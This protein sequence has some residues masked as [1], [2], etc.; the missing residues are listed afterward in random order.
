M[1][2]WRVGMGTLEYERS[3]VHLVAVSHPLRLRAGLAGLTVS[4]RSVYTLLALRS[5]PTM[6]APIFSYLALH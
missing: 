1:E 6:L 3:K 2:Q 4:P 5:A